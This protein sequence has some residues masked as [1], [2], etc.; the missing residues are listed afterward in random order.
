MPQRSYHIG[1]DRPVIGIAVTGLAVTGI[2]V[3]EIAV[4]RVAVPGIAV[5][6]RWSSCSIDSASTEVLK[7][8]VVLWTWTSQRD[9][10]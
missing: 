2:A 9:L 3:T 5:I 10:C 7:A 1:L 8:K 6:G 4:P